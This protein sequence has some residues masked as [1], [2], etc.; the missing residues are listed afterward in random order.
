MSVTLY[1]GTSL[2][3]LFQNFDGECIENKAPTKYGN[4]DMTT[5]LHAAL[6]FSSK[7]FDGGSFIVIQFEVPEEEMIPGDRP[8]KEKKEL[9]KQGKVSDESVEG[10]FTTIRMRTEYLRAIHEFRE[11]PETVKEYRKKGKHYRI[12]KK[13][14]TQLRNYLKERS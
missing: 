12:D 11:K 4:Y 9:M 6:D 3:R 7:H 2:A 10:Y 5:S 8:A 13:Q 1:R 14:E